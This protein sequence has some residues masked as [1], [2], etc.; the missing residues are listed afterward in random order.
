MKCIKAQRGLRCHEHPS[1]RHGVPPVPANPSPKALAVISAHTLIHFR[2]S[3]I[4][5]KPSCA[6][7][8][9]ARPRFRHNNGGCHHGW[10]QWHRYATSL[11][12]CD[13]KKRPRNPGE[14][15]KQ[16]YGRCFRRRAAALAAR[17]RSACG[18]AGRPRNRHAFE[19][20]RLKHTIV[21]GRFCKNFPRAS[22]CVKTGF[23]YSR[24]HYHRDSCRSLWYRHIVVHHVSLLRAR[25]RHVV[26]PAGNK[27]TEPALSMRL[28]RLTLGGRVHSANNARPHPLSTLP[29]NGL[30][31]INR[32]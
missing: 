29:F 24:P 28:R 10:C 25:D 20:C 7:G 4:H 17:S 2:V 6:N 21:R 26:F 8:H 32:K 16:T 14:H 3:P 23:P 30:S 12:P 31:R 18:C 5:V 15:S 27:G 9:G 11:R 1:R 22:Q 13:P 19:R